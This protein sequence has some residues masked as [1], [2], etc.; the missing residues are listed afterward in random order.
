[1]RLL[2]DNAEVR[3]QRV[4]MPSPFTFEAVCQLVG[5]PFRHDKT[6][7]VFAVYPPLI[8]RR[9]LVRF[10]DD[11]TVK[12]DHLQELL[13][14]ELKL[15][16][17]LL[18][19]TGADITLEKVDDP[20]KLEGKKD[21]RS[22]YWDTALLIY[23]GPVV[24]GGIDP[25]VIYP[26]WE[27]PF[28]SFRLAGHLA[29]AS[30]CA[31]PLG[32]RRTSSLKLPSAMKE[33]FAQSRRGVSA[34]TVL[35]AI[36]LVYGYNEPLLE[37]LSVT[38]CNGVLGYFKKTP[39]DASIKEAFRPEILESKGTKVQGDV[40]A[41]TDEPVVGT[42]GTALSQQAKGSVADVG[43]F[44]APQPIAP[45][46]PPLQGPTPP[47]ESLPPGKEEETSAIDNRDLLSKPIEEA[48]RLAYKFL[49]SQGIK[50][51]EELVDEYL[52]YL[53][54]IGKAPDQSDSR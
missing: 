2:V 27:R 18:W 35:L 16:E 10:V 36:P 52:L 22:I 29:L 14:T 49:S 5:I 26:W 50:P 1:M 47:W 9:L 25:L 40:P 44:G 21:A 12:G 30:E 3:S 45:V 17:R 48:R 19:I 15:L 6:S 23:T 20:Q 31:S 11:V 43:I 24:P 7:G 13:K 38:V 53:E 46:E 54:R 8:G 37:N 39:I 28:G 51:T 42:A 32:F 41:K 34:P 4:A 33:W